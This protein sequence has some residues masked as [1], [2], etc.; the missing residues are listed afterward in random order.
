[1]QLRHKTISQCFG[2]SESPLN[3]GVVL[4]VMELATATLERYVEKCV[5]IAFA[6][7]VHF[8][9]QILGGLSFLH[10]REVPVTHGCL[11]P[12]NVHVF[13]SSKGARSVLKL[14][15]VG[16]CFP[17]TAPLQWLYKPPEGVASPKADMYAFG[18]LAIELC[19]TRLCELDAD[20]I[21][22]N[23]PVATWTQGRAAFL[24]TAFERLNKLSIP[25]ASVIIDCCANN[26]ADRLDAKA[27]L[28]RLNMYTLPLPDRGVQHADE[29]AAVDVCRS[30]TRG[31]SAVRA[32]Q[33]K[34]VLA[35][36]S[37]FP[38]LRVVEAGMASLKE[39]AEASSGNR[40]AMA[41]TTAHI[42]IISIMMLY[43]DN[44]QL[45]CL[46]CT[47]LMEM[48]EMDSSSAYAVKQMRNVRIDGG[49][50]VVLQAL[51]RH[52]KSVQ[53]T[54]CACR[55]LAAI[56]RD[57]DAKRLLVRYQGLDHLLAAMV[58]HASNPVVL[59][60]ALTACARCCAGFLKGLKKFISL[61]G[62][63]HVHRA[64][65]D[66]RGVVGIQLQGCRIMECL[67]RPENGFSAVF[68]ETTAI[69]RLYKAMDRHWKVEIIQATG[70]QVL[71]NFSSNEKYK[72]PVVGTDGLTRIYNAIQHHLVSPTV[73]QPAC[74][75]LF[76]LASYPGN[77]D[78]LIRTYGLNKLID[79]MEAHKYIEV[80]QHAC[81]GALQFLAR[82]EKHRLFVAKSPALKLT[83]A[84]LERHVD[85]EL[86]TERAADVLANLTA[87]AACVPLAQATGV[88]PFVV[89][90]V[91]RHG[92]HPVVLLP[93]LTLLWHLC[94]GDAVSE[95]VISHN[96]L[97]LI[98]K[99]VTGFPQNAELLTVACNCL[100]GLCVSD[101]HR[102]SLYHLGALTVLYETMTRLEESHTLQAAA[103]NLIANLAIVPAFATRIVGS[104]GVPRILVAMA[105]H[106]RIRSTVEACMLA[107]AQLMQHPAV[108]EAMLTAGC[109]DRVFITLDR[110][111]DSPLV[112][113]YGLQFMYGLAATRVGR[114]D[115]TARHA[116][117]KI[118]KIRVSNAR[119]EDVVTWAA[120]ALSRMS[121]CG[122]KCVIS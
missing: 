67:T 66:H 51:V 79:A 44:V 59:E 16:G 2:I 7:L 90:A 52:H 101:P 119:H 111:K 114:I 36:M 17:N 39:C 74:T 9:K 98:L 45:Q 14:S 25:I 19:M 105:R 69:K 23:K 57:G 120:R 12:A 81:L 88:L 112:Q 97:D 106:I 10:S 34:R 117:D 102:H 27:A 92:N 64:M 113:A 24:A 30:I 65:D 38:N 53:L 99:I 47:A 8:M 94:T 18:A 62:M 86:C 48:M 75:A 26:P 91:E 80:L 116:V 3:P 50:I 103:C 6:D 5:T 29:I 82:V 42:T 76:H 95:Y 63:E 71:M 60:Y 78:S 49:I 11:S 46:G 20:I 41:D 70:C 15:N 22:L 110:W 77:V 54:E 115:L 118:H 72:G 85:D 68:H 37:E 28:F 32:S 55:A 35:T 93:V 84:A 87:D 121:S 108:T 31:S 1:M 33:V 107:V 100:T 122:G 4:L 61:D 109:V 58:S 73:L 96:G 104:K 89:T 21:P 56:A 13:D 43:P 83:V 40:E